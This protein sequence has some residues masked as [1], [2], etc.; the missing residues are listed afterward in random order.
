MTNDPHG[1][2]VVSFQNNGKNANVTF[3][4]VKAGGNG[5][6]A[7]APKATVNLHDVVDFLSLVNGSTFNSPSTLAFPFVT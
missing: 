7:Y 1:Y 4:N 6:L 5:V 3:D 2:G